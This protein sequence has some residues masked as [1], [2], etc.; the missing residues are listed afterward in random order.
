MALTINE[1]SYITREDA[2]SYFANRLNNETWDS[3]EDPQKDAALIQATQIIEQKEFLGYKSTS[4]QVLKFPRIGLIYDG[5][6][7]D[8]STVPKRVKDA[9]CELAI[10]CL[11]EDYTEP[12]DLSNYKAIK[13]A[14]IEIETRGNGVKGLPPL[15]SKLLSP[16]M[17]SGTRLVR[18]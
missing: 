5:Y 3:A 18:G 11:S 4:A 12:D 16:F 15:V 1:N 17:F 8:G 7:V 6:D 10:W 13:I 9:V 14:V 2:N